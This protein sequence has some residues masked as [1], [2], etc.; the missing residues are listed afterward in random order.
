M[1]LYIKYLQWKNQKQEQMHKS[2]EAEI[3][4]YPEKAEEKKCR[5][6]PEMSAI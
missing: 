2:A 1:M 5:R 4:K 6:A 3:K